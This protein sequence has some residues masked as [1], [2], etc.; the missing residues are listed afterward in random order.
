M[1]LNDLIRTRLPLNRN[2]RYYTGTVFP[3]I[4][5]AD[6]FKNFN[7]FLTLV[8]CNDAIFNVFAQSTNIQF[9][10]EY[11]LFE[12]L[13]VTDR[14][15]TFYP[16]VGGTRDTPDILI[17][18]DGSAPLLIAI[19]AKM[20]GS[21]SRG[22]LID[23]M[24][25]QEK[26]VLLRLKK[27]WPSLHVVH[28]ALLPEPIA[29]KF[30]DLGPGL[31]GFSSRSVIT[32]E[33]LY[34]SFLDVESAQYFLEVLNVAILNYPTL[35]SD[36]TI[37]RNA[38]GRLTG[39]DIVTSFQNKTCPYQISN[40]GSAERSARRVEGH[41]PEKLETTKISSEYYCRTAKPELVSDRG[42][43]STDGGEKS[44]LVLTSR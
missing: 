30:G 13:F 21:V 38:Q 25:R 14:F 10:T 17:F 19:E 5:C 36:G 16:N 34:E 26:E 22:D 37:G 9:F 27:E 24:N 41:R 28:L 1:S 12:S 43:H 15:K 39:Q 35:K 42:I 7:K 11:G 6:N 40:N 31:D 2:E 33:K 29:K 4:V 3:A 23:Q 32:W 8:N 20:Y 18:I 44:S